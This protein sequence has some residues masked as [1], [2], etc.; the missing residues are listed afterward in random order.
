MNSFG[1]I[2]EACNAMGMKF[3][4]EN[5]GFFD[6]LVEYDPTVLDA[7]D[8]SIEALNRIAGGDYWKNIITRYKNSESFCMLMHKKNC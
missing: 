8:K 3:K 4:I 5:G 7:T 6:D 1:F 2:R